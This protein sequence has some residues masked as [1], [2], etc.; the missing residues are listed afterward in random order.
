MLGGAMAASYVSRHAE[1]YDG[2]ILLAAYSTSDL[3]E[4][5]LRVLCI[6]GSEDGVLNRER[7]EGSKANLPDDFEEIVIDGGC[8]AYFGSYGPQDGDGIPTISNE[9]QIVRTAEIIR[10]AVA[11]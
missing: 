2:L 5:A 7:Y 1:A 9:E 4:S 11:K 8:H 10:E 6:Y 3:S